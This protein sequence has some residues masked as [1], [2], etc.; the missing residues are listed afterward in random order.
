MSSSA[1]RTRERRARCL[2]TRCAIF[3]CSRSPFRLL[4]FRSCQFAVD[5]CRQHLVRYLHRHAS[6]TM[7]RAD[8]LQGKY[9]GAMQECASPVRACI[10]WPCLD[11][12]PF[13]P[14]AHS[15][16]QAAGARLYFAC[17]K[18]ARGAIADWMPPSTRPAR[19]FRRSR[20]QYGCCARALVIPVPAGKRTSA[21]RR[22]GAQTGARD[23]RVLV[24][25]RTVLR[26]VIHGSARPGSRGALRP[27]AGPAERRATCAAAL[28]STGRGKRAAPGTDAVQCRP[29]GPW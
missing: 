6:R 16:G 19:K 8:P 22:A 24:L 20:A 29:V 5:E 23:A 10:C 28:G 26:E 9:R 4:T 17:A 21:R 27:A 25:T 18:D 14:A 13:H 2:A 3:W 11:K 1:A 15:R 7:I 12:S